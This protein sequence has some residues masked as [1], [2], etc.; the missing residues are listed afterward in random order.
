VFDA[1]FGATNPVRAGEVRSGDINKFPRQCRNDGAGVRGIRWSWDTGKLQSWLMLVRT[2]VVSVL[3]RDKRNMI[4]KT[5][6]QEATS[7][8]TIVKK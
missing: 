7:S 3:V 8:E 6:G 1:E 4:D 5:R 2:S